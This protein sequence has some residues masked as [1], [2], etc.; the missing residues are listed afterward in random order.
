MLTIGAVVLL[1]PAVVRA[2]DDLKIGTAGAQ[3]LRIPVGARGAAM[4]GSGVAFATGIDALFWNPAGAATIQ[5]VDVM[6]SRREYIA[7]IDVDYIVAASTI[8]DMGVFGITAKILSMG[9]ELITTFEAPNGDGTTFG[10]SFSIIGLSWSR[11][12]TDRVAVGLSGNV[13]YEKIA[14][15]AATGVA[16]DAGVQYNPG[17]NNLTFGAVI[18][19][20][21]PNMRFDGKGFDEDAGTSDD[22]SGRD[23]VARTRSSS[24]E[25]PSYV[26]RGMAYKAMEQNNS[27]VN[28]TGAFQS[29]NFSEDEFRAGGEYAYNDAFFVRAGYTESNQSQYLYGFSAGAGV[30]FEL[31]D[32]QLQVD[33]AWGESEFFDN[34]Q[35]F[36]LTVNF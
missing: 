36:S 27:V 19:N 8:G 4:G 24:F 14:E 10:S 30:Q 1:L 18:K 11:T 21:G 2:G 29:N 5:G 32:T 17:W 22:P 31:G 28:L 13:V 6:F 20:L 34:N 33:Y 15:Q 25:L 12:M 7:D 3:E 16:F 26:Q 9:D 23:H 35:T